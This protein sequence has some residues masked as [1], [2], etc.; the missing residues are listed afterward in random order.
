MERL[1]CSSDAD[2]LI[3]FQHSLCDLPLG[4]FV[5]AANAGMCELLQPH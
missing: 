5:T 1:Q 2:K 4:G 3:S